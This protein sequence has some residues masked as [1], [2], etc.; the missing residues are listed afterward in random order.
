MQTTYHPERV[1]AFETQSHMPHLIESSPNPVREGILTSFTYCS[2]RVCS[3]PSKMQGLKHSTPAF[4]KAPQS[5]GRRQVRKQLQFGS[6]SAVIRV[7]DA[8][9]ARR[10]GT[11]GEFGPWG[12]VGK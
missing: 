9:G 1:L 5:G 11:W 10:K 7:E 6:V 12:E 2:L 4:R 3:V 8:K